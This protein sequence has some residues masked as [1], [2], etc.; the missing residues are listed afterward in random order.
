MFNFRV[1]EPELEKVSEIKRL[2]EEA[3]GI[4]WSSV[5]IS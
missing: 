4:N 2:W 1:S 5:N 3:G